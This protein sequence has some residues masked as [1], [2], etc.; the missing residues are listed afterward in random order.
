[1]LLTLDNANYGHLLIGGN[2]GGLAVDGGADTQANAPGWWQFAR[3][4][5]PDR[6]NVCA[7]G[8]AQMA[9]QARKLA[10]VPGATRG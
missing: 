7:V 8:L 1:M 3:Q 6:H 5:L 10:G 2:T 4:V 9:S